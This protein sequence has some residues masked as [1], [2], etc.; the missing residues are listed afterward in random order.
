MQDS[1]A[2]LPVGRPSRPKAARLPSYSLDAAQAHPRPRRRAWGEVD[3]RGPFR[4]AG[5]RLPAAR[6][7]RAGWSPDLVLQSTQR[8]GHVSTPGPC[9]SPRRGPAGPACLAASFRQPCNGHRV[10]PPLPFVE[11]RPRRSSWA[12]DVPRQPSGATH[13]STQATSV[14]GRHLRAAFDGLPDLGRTR[15]LRAMDRRLRRRP[16]LR[17]FVAAGPADALPHA[18]RRGRDLRGRPKTGRT[19][20]SRCD[21]S[22]TSPAVLKTRPAKPSAPGRLPTR[23]SPS[24]PRRRGR[25]SPSSRT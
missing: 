18:G 9:G 15:E 25:S 21:T 2:G 5:P 11:R 3:L 20:S 7:I 16:V 19:N 23:T 1:C 24:P 10:F 14:V 13:A 8:I 22:A 17:G 6:H 12:E 4:G